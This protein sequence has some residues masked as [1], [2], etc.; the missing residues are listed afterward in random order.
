[1]NLLL[2]DSRV[3]DM[4]SIANSVSINT[5]FVLFNFEN[6][7]L[8][9]LKGA[10]GDECFSNVGI[11][12]HNYNKSSYHFISGMNGFLDN[13]RNVDKELTSWSPFKEFLHFLVSEKNTKSLD[14]ISCNI[15]SNFNWRYVIETLQVECNIKINASSN[16][17]G[18]SGNWILDYGV[19]DLTEVYFT[20]AIKE[21]KYNLAGDTI[22]TSTALSTFS[23]YSWP[24]TIIGGSYGNPTI[25]SIASPQN[26]TQVLNISL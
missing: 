22:S 18:Y 9:D 5:K 4:A 1:M 16:A 3:P 23:G 12:Q 26:I 24:I 2:V 21:W 8:D 19:V 13:I 11:L 6:G 10:I 25:V 7:T 14:L 17:V 15:F 20:D